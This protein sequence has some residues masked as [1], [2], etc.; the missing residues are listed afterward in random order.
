MSA[1]TVYYSNPQSG[2]IRSLDGEMAEVPL[3]L[4]RW[5]V[6]ALAEAAQLE[7]LTVGQFVRRLLNRA[8]QATT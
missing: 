4:P 8:L 7:G 5:Q 2:S 6:D 1:N 3:L